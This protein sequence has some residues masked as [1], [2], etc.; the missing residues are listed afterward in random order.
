MITNIDLQIQPQPGKEQTMKK[1][2]YSLL[3]IGLL[4]VIGFAGAERSQA[5]AETELRPT[6]KAMQ[7]RAGWLKTMTANLDAQKYGDVKKDAKALASQTSAAGKKLPDPLAKELTMKVSTLATAVATAA[8]KK[9]G[10][11]AKTK[12]AEIK[13]TCGECH[14]KIRDKK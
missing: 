11:T 5:A 4:C 2:M 12:L 9:D 7:A 1:T 3:A 8:G 14:A 13:A 6:Q 10:E